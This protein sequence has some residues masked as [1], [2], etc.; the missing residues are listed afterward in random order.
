VTFSITF[1][2][3]A[4]GT[5]T[6]YDGSTAL[7]TGGIS[8]GVAALTTSSLAAGTH[9]ITA[10]GSGPLLVSAPLSQAVNPVSSTVAL[11]VSPIRLS[12]SASLTASGS[13][14]G[15]PERDVLR[16]HDRCRHGTC[17]EWRCPQTVSNL[18]AGSHSITAAWSGRKR[19]RPP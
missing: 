11:N 19:P 15:Q 4:T 8:N 1:P 2:A 12:K 16:W 18:A 14:R 3:D 6:F 5:V 17:C 9:S 10:G 13:R 7:G